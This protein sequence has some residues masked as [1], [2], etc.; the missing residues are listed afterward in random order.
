[1]TASTAAVR[2]R[3]TNARWFGGAL[4]GAVAPHPAAQEGDTGRECD[5]VLDT[6][7]VLAVMGAAYLNGA[8]L[9]EALG[10]GSSG[11]QTKR[12]AATRAQ[13]VRSLP[14]A[15]PAATAGLLVLDADLGGQGRGP[16]GLLHPASNRPG[17]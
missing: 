6:G 8:R 9:G 11:P 17:R 5:Q 15:T 10:T 3:L 1:M 2:S 14:W 13:R 16:A 12:K 4:M 7:A